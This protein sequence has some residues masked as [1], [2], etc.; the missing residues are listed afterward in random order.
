MAVPTRRTR[1]TDKPYLPDPLAD[2]RLPRR[3]MARPVAVDAAELPTLREAITPGGE[4]LLALFDL[5]AVTGLRL[6]E[7]LALRLR[8][9]SE[10]VVDG[11]SKV[12]V[13]VCGT[14]VEKPALHRQPLPKTKAGNRRISVPPSSPA[15]IALLARKAHHGVLPGDPVWQNAQGR[16]LFQG[17]IN[18]RLRRTLKDGAF[19]GTTAHTLRR[20]VASEMVRTLGERA[21]ADLL[22]HGDPA[23]TNRHYVAPPTLVRAW[24]G[25]AGGNVFPLGRGTG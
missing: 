14:M 5:L 21:A 12:I 17:T 2:V 23:V 10:G 6:G 4:D 8:D 25:T 7:A 16:W 22:G 11:D 19:E 13:H 20:T 15:G 18:A 9:V 24:S 3:D 1:G